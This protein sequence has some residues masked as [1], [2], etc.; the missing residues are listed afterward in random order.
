MKGVVL[1]GGR[2]TRL[3]PLTH[4]GPKQLIPVANKPISQYVLEDLKNAGID[5]IAIILGHIQPD[6]VR[7]KYGD[8]S[9]LGL[10]ISYIR[11]DEPKGIAHAVKLCREFVGDEL[12]AVYLGDNLIKGGIDRLAEKFENSDS[13]ALVFLNEVDKPQ[14]FGV[15][16][17]D[18][19]GN[20]KKLVEKPEDPPS[21]YA[22]TGIYFFS[23]KIFEM[24]DKI[25]PSWR[26]ELEI[27]D[28]IQLLLDEGYDVDYDKVQGW[29]KD[30][31][32]PE[33]VLEA[34]RLILDNLKPQVNCEVDGK[35]CLQ[36]RVS[37]GEGS[38]VERGAKVRGPSIIGNN[39]VIKSGVYIGPYTSIGDGVEIMEGEIE[40]S[41]VMNNCE[42]RVGERI[43][44]SLIGPD[45]RIV[46]GDSKPTGRSM[47]L[48]KS[49]EVIL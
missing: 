31:G 27:T 28:A 19:E 26:G 37:V 47:I 42:I 22:L 17:F 21:N 18:E 4:T 32:T 48:G 15:A 8:G 23:P 1:H 35:N 9:Q 7:E 13:E 11:Q 2:G 43:V 6:I 12:F 46:S 44:N 41:I 34:N 16:K 3:R 45:S 10:D 5:E 29:W 36:G 40:N 24:I 20:L 33:D 14:Q 30:T 49:S 25:E 39:T 38:T